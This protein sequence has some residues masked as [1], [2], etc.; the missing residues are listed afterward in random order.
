M[1]NIS[2]RQLLKAGAVTGGAAALIGAPQLLS[3]TSSAA[4]AA[5]I[6]PSSIPKYVT[7]LF[8]LPAM[9]PS[10]AN[11]W[12]V[13]ARRF[14]QQILPA[15][16]PATTVFGM[17][18]TANPRTNHAPAYTI[19]ARAN[20]MSHVTWVNQLVDSSGNY[21]PHLLPVDPTLHWANP[22]G[23]T[24]GRDSQ[25][26]FTS[27]PAAYTG[28]VPFTAHLHGSHDFEENDGYPESWFLPGGEEHPGG[29]RDRRLV[30]RPV[31]GGGA[32]DY[33]V[34]WQPG[35]AIF[36]VRKR[37]ARHQPVVPR[38]QPGHDPAERPHPAWWATYLLRGGSSDLP[39]GSA[40]RP[41]AQA[42]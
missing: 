13:A 38:P 42:G 35:S 33:G 14:T 34:K 23:G 10:G 21:V 17:G 41:R 32:A 40:A 3:R 31:Q 9:P 4:R 27:T 18:S 39:A 36:S 1:P 37:P 5:T 19:E 15:G 20:Q 22:P 24:S 30:L 25:P 29:L 2:R 26:V 11:A 6:T 7:P 8:I 28:P 12:S 16:F